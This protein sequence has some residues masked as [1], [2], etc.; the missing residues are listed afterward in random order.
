MTAAA[1]SLD[2]FQS[3]TAEDRAALAELVR[4]PIAFSGSRKAPDRFRPLL[5]KGLAYQSAVR[6][7]VTARGLEPKESAL[8]SRA[9]GPR[10]PA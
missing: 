2:E 8:H 1:F 4:A 5:A 3:L 6:L 9:D 10:M 7:D